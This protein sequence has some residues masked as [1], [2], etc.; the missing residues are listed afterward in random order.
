MNKKRIIIIII[1]AL[2]LLSGCGTVNDLPDNENKEV[3]ETLRSVKGLEGY[4]GELSEMDYAGVAEITVS[5]VH[6]SVEIY[7]ASIANYKSAKSISGWK[8]GAFSTFLSYIPGLAA[9]ADAEEGETRYLIYNEWVELG[10]YNIYVFTD[11]NIDLS[12]KQ[13]KALTVIIEKGTESSDTPHIF[14]YQFERI[15]GISRTDMMLPYS[16]KVYMSVTE[17]NPW[18]LEGDQDIEW[19]DYSSE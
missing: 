15:A 2:A 12:Y 6:D 16:D 11:M 14:I 4:L 17:L 10:E 13:V 7:N 18:N 5:T 1:L 8:N 3:M 19:F 9:K